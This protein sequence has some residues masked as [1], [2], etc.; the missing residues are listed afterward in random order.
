MM[1]SYKKLLINFASKSSN[2]RHVS[3]AQKNFDNLAYQRQPVKNNWN[4][5]LSNAEK[6]VGYKRSFLSLSNL[7]SDEVTQLSLHLTKLVGSSHP[8]VET[9]KSLLFSHNTIKNWG[10]IVL[11][12]SKMAG[13]HS[14]CP[15]MESEKI[16]GI[17][18][19][20][21]TIAEITEILRLANLVHQRVINLQIL[22]NA[23]NDLSS[24]SDMI[25][26]NKIAVLGGD[27]LFGTANLRISSLRNQDISE[28]ISTAIRDLADSSFIGDHDDQNIPLPSD[29]A[30][31][32][33][34]HKCVGNV[35]DINNTLPFK[36]DG[37][38][39]DPECEWELRTI[40]SG[41]SLLGKSCQSALIL[42]KQPQ[43]FQRNAYLFG[44]HVAL[45]WQASTDLE[46]FKCAQMITDNI[47]LIS[48]PVLFQL[49][50]DHELYKEIKKGIKSVENIDFSRIFEEVKNGPGLEKTHE[51][52]GKHILKAMTELYKFPSS[53]ARTA[54]EN[55]ILAMQEI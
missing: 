29:P 54:L 33:T 40:L 11:L 5:T 36:I 44:K 25:Y 6:I 49:K 27:F 43:E 7:L 53:E 2:I 31:Y 34:D 51:L 32:N 42:S 39:N 52:Q 20:Q 41:G 23:G 22:C 55:V 8:L 47:S 35:D 12:V 45:A 13:Q 48:A 14:D 37:F 17:L 9:A 4:Q 21:R 3:T 24:D 1:K 30:L 28:L 10:L 15:I 26:G 19:T 38:M 16:S 50:H 18:N 46:P